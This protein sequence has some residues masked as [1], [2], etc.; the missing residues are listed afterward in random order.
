MTYPSAADSLDSLSAPSAPRARDGRFRNPVRMHKMGLFKT[1]GIMLRFA[2][3][4]PK[5][6][7]PSLPIPVHAITQQQLMD[8]PDRSLF[9]LGHSTVL[10]KLN[11]DF[12]LT[13]P[14][15]SER[16]SP[17]QWAG[18]QRFHAPPISIEDLPPIKGIILSHDH[19]DHLDRAAVL[20]LAGKTEHFVT[21]LGVGDRL[22]K[23]GIPAC[24]VRQLGWWQSATVAGLKLVATPAQHF[25]GR[26]LGD[27]NKTLWASFVVEDRDVRLFFSG[28]SG[29]FDGFKE[30]GR[31]Y[32]PFDLTLVE[33]G[34]YDPQWPDVHMQPEESL[35]AHIDLRG[36][37]LLPIHNGTFDLSLHAWHDPFDRIT[38]LA[39]ERRVA[40]ATPEI[41]LPLDIV[42]PQAEH[43]WWEALV[44]TP[45]R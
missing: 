35:Q 5:D 37:V 25:S 15:F 2:F 17:V 16:A 38:E 8:A 21:P 45:S 43:K 31:R 3:D 10:L 36:K 4:K 26:G 39:Q 22:I 1:L 23:W 44:T 12:W 13:D 20:A 33:T 11:G 34:A 40:I 41:G 28:D 18:P 30:I 14:V 19:Y 27:R 32:G 29:Y 42:Q 6:T 7:V 24:K 9:R